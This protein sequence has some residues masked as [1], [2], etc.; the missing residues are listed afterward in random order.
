LYQTRPRRPGARPS[1]AGVAVSVVVAV[2]VAMARAAALRL[3]AQPVDLDAV[4]L[5]LLGAIE[6]RE[7]AVAT[8]ERESR[9]GEVVARVGLD[10]AAGAA[11]SRDGS[12]EERQRRLR[13]AGP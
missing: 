11:E 5:D 8:S 4:P 12:L 13:V 2:P 10:E 6:Q 9:P 3:L 7:D 1:V